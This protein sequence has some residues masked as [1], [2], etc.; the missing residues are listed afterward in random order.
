MFTYQVKFDDQTSLETYIWAPFEEKNIKGVVQI[1]H[2]M[3]EYMSRYADF[4]KL[5]FTNINL[6]VCNC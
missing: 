6:S 5:S 4:A 3:A 1:I 2:G